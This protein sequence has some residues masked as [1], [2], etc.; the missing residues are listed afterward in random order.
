MENEFRNKILKEIA[1]KHDVNMSLKWLI[2][3]YN[4]EYPKLNITRDDFSV[5]VAKSP[6]EACMGFTIIAIPK[7]E[8]TLDKN[9]V[10]RLAKYY[11]KLLGNA[12]K[13]HKDLMLPSNIGNLSWDD[14][15]EL[16][17]EDNIIIGDTVIPRELITNEYDNVGEVAF[18]S[19]NL[20]KNNKNSIELEFINKCC[21][22]TKIN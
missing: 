9:E 8:E 7:F 4:E 18:I 5:R 13:N 16:F 21:H 2:K 10:Y 19:N 11:D 22:F 17:K 20:S 14:L 6:Y 12:F 15:D 3:M 1:R